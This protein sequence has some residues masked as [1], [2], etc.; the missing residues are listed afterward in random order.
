MAHCLEGKL[1]KQ[2]AI[3]EVASLKG[4]KIDVFIYPDKFKFVRTGTLFLIKSYG[5]YPIGMVLKLIHETRTGS[6]TPLGMTRDELKRRYPDIE[7][8]EKFVATLVYVGHFDGSEFRQ[9]RASSP[10]IH[11]LVFSLDDC[12]MDFIK[13]EGKWNFYFLRYFIA[14]GATPFEVKEFFLNYTDFWKENLSEKREILEAIF[15]SLSFFRMKDIEP[16]LVE[17]IDFFSKL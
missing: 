1:I 3:G 11:D 17:I 12:L 5:V 7:D 14:E 6:F 9:F 15:E 4:G 2:N 13:H 16:Y 10:L 8:Y